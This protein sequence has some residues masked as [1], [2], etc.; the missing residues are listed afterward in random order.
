[1]K[2][3]KA[4]LMVIS[5]IFLFASMAFAA[6]DMVRTVKE[7]CSQD[8]K[9]FCPKVTPGEARILACLYAYGDK[10]SSRCE[11]A[12]YDASV[13]LERRV[14]AINYVAS[15]CRQD[16]SAYCSEI[17]SGGGRL[18]NCLDQHKSQVSARCKQAVKDVGI[19]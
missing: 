6:E 1:M 16:L 17:K 8:I 5:F 13:Q 10:I 11:Y 14:N 15:E 9:T 2:Q 3:M 7:G 18:L 12:L 19:R 4:C